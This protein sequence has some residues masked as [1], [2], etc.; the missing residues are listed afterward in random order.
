MD[1]S[2]KGKL[3]KQLSSEKEMLKAFGQ[4]RAKPLKLRLGVLAKA[5][6]LADVPVDPPP[7]CHQLKGKWKGQFAVVLIGNWRL[8]FEPDPPVKGHVNLA[9]VKKIRLLEVVDYHGE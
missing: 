6:T 9:D 4:E 2:F 1:F 5:N 7:R 8:V 3:K